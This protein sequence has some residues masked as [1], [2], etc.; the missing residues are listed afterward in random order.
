LREAIQ[1]DPRDFLEHAAQLPPIL[2]TETP[3][4]G[5]TGLSEW[6]SLCRCLQQE[7]A[8]ARLFRLQLGDHPSI[9]ADVRCQDHF[10]AA[11]AAARAGCGL[12]KDADTLSET[13][14][15]AWRQQAL[16]WLRFD[17]KGW[18][19]LLSGG[20]VADRFTARQSLN[21]WKCHADLACVRDP[22]AL[23][24]LPRPEHDSWQAFWTEVDT[25]LR[26]APKTN[27]GTTPPKTVSNPLAFPN[28][29]S[30]GTDLL[31]PP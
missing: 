14:R 7:A 20:D 5:T 30:K 15:A 16:D 25:A 8:A 17:L 28:L 12:G 23:A 13:E 31:L 2:K 29:I 21:V 4:A 10:E 22:A 11:C 27:P 3:P 6:A 24:R 9:S 1:I 18:T 19:A 26:N